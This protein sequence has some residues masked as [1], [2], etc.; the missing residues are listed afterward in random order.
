MPSR[1]YETAL[2]LIDAYKRINS[3]A[4]YVLPEDIVKIVK[5][6]AAIAVATAF[7]PIGGLDMAAATVNI[8]T[9]Y[10]KINTAL[11][12]KFSDNKMKSIGSAIASNLVLNL[13][14]SAVVSGLKF[15]GVGYFAAIAILTTSMYA[16]TMTAGWVYL[17]ALTNMALYDKDID[18]S[19]KDVLKDKSAIDKVYNENKKK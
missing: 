19:V 7:I 18:D 9:M 1:I 4:S 15:T 3:A 16:L 2:K 11:G 8:W 5:C 17:K 12:I 14:V 10:T 13:G 6:H